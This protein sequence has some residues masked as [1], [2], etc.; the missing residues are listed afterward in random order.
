[1]VKLGGG[2]YIPPAAPIVGGN[3]FSLRRKMEKE[4]KNRRLND[5]R[6]VHM[7]LGGN[8]DVRGMGRV[9]QEKFR[10]HEKVS[11][12]GQEKSSTKKCWRTG[13]KAAAP[14]RKR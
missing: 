8:S 14:A 11:K 7:I 2:K 13:G 12:P 10:G 6:G 3:T 5:R 1:V 9:P 4:K